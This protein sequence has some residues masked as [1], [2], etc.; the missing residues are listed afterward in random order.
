MRIIILLQVVTK[1]TQLS[2]A[3]APILLHLY[4]E[5][6]KDLLAQKSLHI[7]AGL[8][9]HL[10]QALALVADDDSLLR[11]AGNIDCS[12]GAVD[13]GLLLVGVNLNLAA[14]GYLLLV[15]Q[16]NLLADNLRGKE[17]QSLVRKRILRIEG[18]SLGQTLKDSIQ[19]ALHSHLLLG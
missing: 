13:S 19:H 2:L 11:L 9:S 8:L 4:K 18:L 5:L 16:E 17:A 3:V 7:L 1:A 14:V 15:V 12:R 10:L 6:Q